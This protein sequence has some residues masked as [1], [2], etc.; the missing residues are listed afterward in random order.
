MTVNTQRKR[1]TKQPDVRRQ[2]LMD[3]AVRVFVEKGI[4]RTT[5]SDITQSAGVAK[6]TFYLY[7]TSKENLL[8]ALKERFVNDVL[9]HAT[10]HYERVGREDWWA[11]A[12]S[13]IESFT[14]FML[15]RKDMIHVIVQ[16]G[17]AP[18]S[19]QLF[20]ECE[21]KVDAMFAAGIQAGI[22]AGVFRTSDPEL[23]GRFI[24]HAFDGAL[25]HGILYGPPI[26]RDRFVA[27][28]KELVRKALAP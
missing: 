9:A 15:E 18:E 25:T 8:G 28:A 12:D 14:D 2:E 10:S 6:G 27:A 1:V 7:F 11:L 22:Q 19:S 17:L 3:A 26:D 4:A 20:A 21:A 24:H 5:V 13:I 23:L 16:E